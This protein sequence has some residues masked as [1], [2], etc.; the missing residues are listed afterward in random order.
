[1]TINGFVY[2]IQGIVYLSLVGPENKCTDG[3]PISEGNYIKLLPN[4]LSYVDVHIKHGTTEIE[5]DVFDWVNECMNYN[6]GEIIYNIKN[7]I[8]FAFETAVEDICEHGD[9]QTLANDLLNKMDSVK[10]DLKNQINA[11]N[12]MN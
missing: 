6:Q 4:Q 1:M 8:I 11:K 7:V 5:M 12:K 9:F 3:I 10:N 2:K